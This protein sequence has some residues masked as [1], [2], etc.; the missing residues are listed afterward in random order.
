MS[1]TSTVTTSVVRDKVPGDELELAN[2]I[3]IL[4]A[5]Q[6]DGTPFHQ[7][8]FQEEDMVKLYVGLGQVHPKGVLWLLD[9]KM[10]LSFNVAPK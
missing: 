9:T 3:C 8:S 7:N 6:G 1:I 2:L 10:I 4:V 5:T